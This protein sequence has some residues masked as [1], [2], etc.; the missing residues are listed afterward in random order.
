M[1]KLLNNLL[2]HWQIANFFDHYLKVN[3]FYLRLNFHFT[4]GFIRLIHSLDFSLLQ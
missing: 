3:C 4:L 1:I 2:L